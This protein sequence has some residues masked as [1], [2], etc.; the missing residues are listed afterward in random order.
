LDNESSNVKGRRVVVSGHHLL[1]AGIA[2][3]F[4]DQGGRVAMLSTA[5]PVDGPD[6]PFVRC[7]FR[8]EREVQDAIEAAA[9]AIGGVDQLVHGWVADGLV[10]RRTFMDIDERTWIDTC[11]ASLEGLWWLT[12]R[13]IAPLRASGGGSIV[14]LVPSVGLSGAAHYSMLATVAEGTR[15]LAKGCGRQWLKHGVTVN[16]IATAPGL[17]VGAENEEEL[18]RAISLAV[19]A[20]GRAGDPGGDLAPL[21]SALGQSECH[22]LSAGTLVADG[23]V[24]TGL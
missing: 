22:F 17:W 8:S 11:E 13:A 7:A 3:W 24:W 16:T 15:V 14:Y 9:S 4:H 19:P 2:R 18:A 1:S 21:V 23:G 12:R 6:V 20:Y 5:P 10:N